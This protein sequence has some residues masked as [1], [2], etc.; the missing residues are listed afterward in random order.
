MIWLR[1]PHLLGHP[2]NIVD[3]IHGL[4]NLDSDGGRNVRMVII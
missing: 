1:I 2:S 4:Q 3:A